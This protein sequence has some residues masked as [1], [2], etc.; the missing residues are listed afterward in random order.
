MDT[1]LL[2]ILLITV[3][4]AVIAG[5]IISSFVQKKDSF[6][7]K[8]IIEKINGI[9]ESFK[10]EFEPVKTGLTENKTLIG[11]K[12][13]DIERIHQKFIVGPCRGSSVRLDPPE[14]VCLETTKILVGT[15][16]HRR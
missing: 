2:L 10:E 6:S 13:V 12:A 5:N 8:E 9:K 7:P 16:G 11:A 14:S 15:W 3:I 1:G 4:V